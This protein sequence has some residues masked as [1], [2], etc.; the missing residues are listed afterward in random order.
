MI[1]N[2]QE[3]VAKVLGT[4]SSKKGMKLLKR[5]LFLIVLVAVGGPLFLFWRRSAAEAKAPEYITQSARRGN[6]IVNVTATGTLE[7]TN[8]VEVG[9]E[10]S[11][12][13]E[14]VDVDYNDH[15]KVG[16]VL[17]KLDT[18]KLEAQVVRS[19]SALQSARANVLQAEASVLETKNALERMKKVWEKTGKKAPSQNEMDAAEAA[20]KRALAAE[21]SS[22]AQVSEAEATLNG[23]QTDLSKCVIRSP[24]DGIVLTRQVEPGQTVAASLQAP[25]LF[26]LAEDLTKMELRVDVDEA[27]VGEVEEGQ[28]ATFTVDA[29]PDKTFDATVSQVRYGS[30]TVNGVVTYETILRVQ[31]SDLLLRPG[32]T[33]TAE[34]TVKKLE[35]ALLIPNGALRFSPPIEEKKEASEGGSITS[36]LFGRPFRRPPERR[37]A[38]ANG[39]TRTVWT[40]KDGVPVPISVTLGPTDGQ[41]T[42]V[43]TGDVE[44]DMPLLVG[45]RETSA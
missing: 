1:T 3:D 45:L 17:A 34:I 26:T 37:D 33:A 8:Q 38:T 4:A 20:Y 25:T 32:M 9:S 39:K 43:V 6:M 41:M 30:K 14:S 29:Y 36:K 22:K 5:T 42:E 31:N 23:N 7:P 10:L 27:D 2:K 40:L 16:Q 19:E 18:E 21:A 15:V 24:I 35:D 12:I 11:G 28:E 44:A 13:I